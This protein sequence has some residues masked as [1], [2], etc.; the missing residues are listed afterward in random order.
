MNGLEEENAGD[1]QSSSYLNV[2]RLHGIFE[3]GQN[4]LNSKICITINN[5]FAV[6]VE[7]LRSFYNG[8]FVQNKRRIAHVFVKPQRGHIP[9]Y[10]TKPLIYNE[11]GGHI[12][13]FVWLNTTPVLPQTLEVVTKRYKSEPMAAALSGNFFIKETEPVVFNT[14]EEYVIYNVSRF[15]WCPILRKL[16]YKGGRATKAAAVRY[17]LEELMRWRSL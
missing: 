2:P 3:D 1:A 8:F 13:Q 6:D 16:N 17:A 11:T 7:K 15:M 5:E 10:R 4:V 9:T 12:A 14:L